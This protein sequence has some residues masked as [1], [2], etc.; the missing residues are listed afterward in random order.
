[1]SNY[2]AWA[3]PQ[4]LEYPPGQ[5]SLAVT[6]SGYMEHSGDMS[7]PIYFDYSATTPVD[8]RVAK[9]MMEFLTPDTEF[10]NPASRSHEYGWHAEEA[11]EIARKQV[12]DLIESTRIHFER[13]TE[14]LVSALQGAVRL[15]QENTRA[16]VDD[17]EYADR[18]NGLQVVL[19]EWETT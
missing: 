3:D 5:P 15:A 16:I 17:E 12:A 18:L 9:K 11:I 19:T 7:K 13:M 8:P 1:M 4:Q 14:D 10:G 6:R 2:L